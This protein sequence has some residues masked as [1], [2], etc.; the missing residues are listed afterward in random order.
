[1]RNQLVIRGLE[2][3]QHLTLEAQA[4]RVA[5]FLTSDS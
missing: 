3:V 1:L 2:L 4:A 5:S